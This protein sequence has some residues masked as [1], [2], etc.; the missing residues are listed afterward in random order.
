[1][2]LCHSS[3]FYFLVLLSPSFSFTF[4]HALAQCTLLA[5]DHGVAF[6][7]LSSGQIPNQLTKQRTFSCQSQHLVCPLTSYPPLALARLPPPL[8]VSA[9][10]GREARRPTKI[11]RC[12]LP[13]P[14]TRAGPV[15]RSLF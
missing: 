3:Q 15:G 12:F 5:V 6:L 7:V 2:T 8:L 14:E 10:G 13:S 4:P 11:H 1:M 9:Q